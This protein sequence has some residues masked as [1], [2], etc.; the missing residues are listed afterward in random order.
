MNGV[1]CFVT[2]APITTAAITTA[3]T[4]TATPSSGG[5]GIT[6]VVVIPVVAVVI[7]VTLTVGTLYLLRAWEEASFTFLN[8][9]V[10][11]LIY[12]SILHVE[13]HQPLFYRT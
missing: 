6:L 4:T 3:A 2:I 10:S 8:L 5:I 7:I 1:S 11:F 13:L 9:K 12:G